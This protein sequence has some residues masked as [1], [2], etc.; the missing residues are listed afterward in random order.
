MPFLCPPRVLVTIF[1]VVSIYITTFTSASGAQRPLKRVSHPSTL[2]IEIYPRTSS[3]NH[4]RAVPPDSTTL[5]CSDSFRLTLTAFD[6]TFHLHLRPND[7]LVHPSARIV[8]Y[9]TNPAGQSVLS[10]TEPL[11]PSSIKAYWGE[12]VPAHASAE[13]MRTDAARALYGAG[14]VLGWARITVHDQG[15]ARADRPPVFEGAFSVRGINHHVMTRDNYLRN[16]NALDPHLLTRRLSPENLDS[17]SESESEFDLDLDPDS[18]LV[19]WRDSDVMDPWEEYAA[20][21]GVPVDHL[22]ER[23][24]LGSE[25]EA[26]R[27]GHDALPWNSDPVLNPVLQQSTAGSWYDAFGP[28]AH[29]SALTELLMKRDDIAGS[30]M[31]TNFADTIGQ[32]GGCPKEQKVLYM[33]VAADCGYV[34]HY[35]SQANATKQILTIWNTASVLYKNTFNVSL[36]I[37]ELQIQN[38]TCPTV[39]NPAVPW[40][41]NCSTPNVNLDNRLSFF[42]QWRGAKGNDGAGLWHLMSNCPSGSEVGIA[43]LGTLCQINATGSGSSIVSGTGVSTAGLTEWQVI[44]HEMGHNFGAIHDCADGCNNTSACCPLSASSCDANSN[45]LMSPVASRGEMNFSQCSIGN[46]CSLM[47][48]SQASKVDTSCL[49]SP[50]PTR[51][52]I[53]L[54]MCGNGIVESGEDC[55]PGKGS[56]STCC[57]PDTCKFR[58]NAVCDPGSAP[59]C[60]AQCQFAPATQ[61]CRASRDATCDTAE[62]CTGNSS[63]CP[64]DI[65]APNGKSCGANDLACAS[66]RCTSIAQQCQQLGASLNLQSACPNRNDQSC[67]VSCQA[68]TTPNQCVLL[69]SLLIDG[70]PCGYGGTC[71]NGTCQSG[72]VFDT[73]KAWYVQNLQ[74]SIPI[75]VAAVL[76]ALAVLWGIITC[77]CCSRRKKWS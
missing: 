19:I 47:Q 63:A 75:T 24:S 18:G 46:I 69:D 50:D 60:T 2:A 67:K 36:G 13:R 35:G 1:I 5:H 33:G 72:S 29:G 11:V 70:S 55:D 28:V 3:L 12:V 56:N 73:A 30:G 53:S 17:E 9:D 26:V 37:V 4:A 27:C 49:L 45:F 40:N 32:T 16:R 25:S 41:V 44:A 71:L 68:P 6:E 23:R 15:D 8:Y 42:S 52:T 22:R 39:A 58:N 20:R 74:I 31:S 61:I 57:D 21:T 14:D 43:W 76:L 48:G 64:A 38:T 62:L 51:Q 59:C 66:G 54:Q 34:N 65:F 7:Q 10:H 77:C